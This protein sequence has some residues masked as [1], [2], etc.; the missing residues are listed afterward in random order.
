M[1]QLATAVTLCCLLQKVCTWRALRMCRCVAAAERKANV[2]SRYIGSLAKQELKTLDE[3][4]AGSS[5]DGGGKASV[6][7]GTSD[8]VSSSPGKAGNLSPVSNRSKD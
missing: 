3:E 1:I 7:V 6:T 5:V 2:Q 8:P 4:E